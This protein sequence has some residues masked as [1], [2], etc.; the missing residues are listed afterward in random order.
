MADK[1]TDVKEETTEESQPSFAKEDPGEKE[2]ET[3][4][5]KEDLSMFERNLTL[6]DEGAICVDSNL[7][8]VKYVIVYIMSRINRQINAW[9]KYNIALTREEKLAN[10][11]NGF[12]PEVT[13]S[14]FPVKPIDPATGEPEK[15]TPF[16]LITRLRNQKVGSE[17]IVGAEHLVPRAYEVAVILH[18]MMWAYY[19]S[20]KSKEDFVAMVQH[21]QRQ[22]DLQLMQKRIRDSIRRKHFEQLFS[23]KR[24]EMVAQNIPCYTADRMALVRGGSRA[25]R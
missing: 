16:E 3:K 13:G 18:K 25:T 11:E 24:H 19:R 17:L 21:N 22:T 7:Q 12:R 14:E 8:A 2:E 6:P 15:L 1:K 10:W 4:E 23:S 20:G 9:W 5:S